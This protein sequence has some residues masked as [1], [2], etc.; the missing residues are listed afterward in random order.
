MH[1]DIASR[2]VESAATMYCP[3]CG[4]ANSTEQRFCRT[5]GFSLEKTVQS[6]NEQLPAGPPDERIQKRQRTVERLVHVAGG[7]AIAIVVGAVLWGIIYE[8]IIVKGEVLGGSIFLALIV[9]LILVAALAVYQDSLAKAS[10]KR[11]L[12]ERDTARVENTADPL[13]EPSVESNPSITEHTT[14]FLITDKKEA[15]SKL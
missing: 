13:L 6:L 11:H 7:G 1:P 5:C 3:N 2:V 4:R 10:A 8:I 15:E 14:E 12:I 9:G